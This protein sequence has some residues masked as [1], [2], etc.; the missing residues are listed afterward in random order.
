MSPRIETDVSIPCSAE[1]SAGLQIIVCSLPRTGTTSIK[2]A[3]EQL[4]FRNVYHMRTFV[5]HTEDFN[6][7]VYAIKAKISG[8]DIP[9]AV[10]DNLL[11]DYHA[12]VDAPG[13][14]FAIELAKAYPNAKVIMLNRDSEKWYDSF[15][16]TV[17]EMIKRRESFEPF[18]WMLRPWL[19]TQASAIIRMGNLLS[20]SGVGLGSYSK[21]D[22]LK[23]FHEYYAGCRMNI[24]AESC[25]DFKVQDGWAPLCEHLGVSVPGQYTADGWVQSPFPQV[26]DTEAFG[27]WV[28]RLQRSMVIQTQRNMV[29]HALIVL[30]VI[31]LVR[32]VK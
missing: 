16:K 11:G 24:P 5:D 8:H 12:I 27:S 32:L 23:F 1:F 7:W 2:L 10:W 25:I 19:P 13:C 22:C 3:L 30:G 15:A 28:G 20:K 9:R 17:Q 21:E 26:N 29:L 31:V 6:N 4:G 18:E 14:Y